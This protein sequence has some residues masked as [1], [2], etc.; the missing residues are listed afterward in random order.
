MAQTIF[1]NLKKEL[2]QR[3]SFQQYTALQEDAW[4][5]TSNY[6]I[7][8]SP[9][10]SGKTIAFVIRALLHL[11]KHPNA[12]IL[13]LTPTRELAIQI[14]DVIKQ[15]RV[16]YSSLAIYGGNEFKRE[17]NQLAE[18]VNLVIATPGRLLDHM[19]RGAL[20]DVEFDMLILDEYDKMLEIGFHNELGQ[21][22]SYQDHWKKIILNSAT[23]I[24]EIPSF[25][26]QYTFET[27]DYTEGN[28]PKIY[29]H[30]V[31]YEHEDKLEALRNIALLHPEKKKIIFTTHR[32]RAEMVYKYFHLLEFPC[33]LFHGGMDQRE[34][35]RELI[36]FEHGS[37]TIMI[38]TDLG[39]RGID[40]D[41]I[42]EVI[43]YQLPI[44]ND[45]L[46]NNADTHRNGRTGRMNKSGDVYYL[47]DESKGIPDFLQGIEELKEEAQEAE[48]FAPYSTLYLPLGKKNKIRKMDVVG[49]F[50]KTGEITNKELGKITLKDNFTYVSVLSSHANK[51]K[52]KVDNQKMK[53]KKVR[54]SWCR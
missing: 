41:D 39:A 36:K 11:Q 46:K 9:T 17:E 22:V 16:E 37:T 44:Q 12:K 32:E 27:K 49:F 54:V 53:N 42:E 26:N 3:F 1:M 45:S 10:G 20:Q 14:N 8:I 18:G 19:D 47:L 34:R 43:H 5:S 21:I 24:E 51:V 48:I 13:V 4:K 31:M 35:E 30:L 25:I 50:C 40:I 29:K 7:V 15:S 52:E 2:L 33:S 23:Q 28:K 6:Q 38:C